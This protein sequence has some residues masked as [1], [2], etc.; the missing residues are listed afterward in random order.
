MTSLARFIRTP[1]NRR[2]YSSFF[3]SKPGGGGRYFNPTKSNKSVPSTI[4]KNDGDRHVAASPSCTADSVDT[5]SGSDSKMNGET[6]LGKERDVDASISQA[7]FTQP[8]LHSILDAK[9][10]KLHQFF[11]VHRPLLLLSSPSSILASAPPSSVFSFANP[12]RIAETEATP[13]NLLDNP[14]ETSPEGDTE[15]ARQLTYALT[16]NHAG[17]A[18]EW[19][20]TLRRLGLDIDADAD[21][22]G[23]QERLDKE[24]QDVMM[25]STKRKRKKKMKKHKLKKR[26]RLTRASRQRAR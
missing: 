10:F 23:L 5:L 11:S 19:E 12:S 3:S 4:K 8:P 7:T 6:G 20:M 13:S 2:T 9:E 21:R 16:M 14:P 22:V 18:A 15:T 17:A 24:F 1:A 26:R 25:D